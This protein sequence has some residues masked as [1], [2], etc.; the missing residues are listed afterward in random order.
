MSKDATIDR[1]FSVL[2]VGSGSREHALTWGLATSPSVSELWA[3][4]G[5]PGIATLARTLDLP[6]TDIVAIADLAVALQ[7]GLVVVG[8]EAPL[9]FGLANLLRE[10]GIPVFGPTREAAELEWSK[11]FAKA[12]MRRHGIPTADFGLFADYDAAMAFARG[13]PLPLVVKAD[14]LAGGKGVVVCA[15]LAE[16]EGAIRSILLDDAFGAAG[17][18]VVIEEFLPGEELSVIALVDGERIALLPAARDYKRLGDGDSGPNTGG[19]GSYAPVP[20]LDPAL[21]DLVR[22][23]VLEPA[24]AGLR[25]EGR[26]Y[27]GALYAGLML[28]TSGPRVLEFNC[29]FGD[30]E[31][32]AILP[33][34]DVDLARLLYDTAE[35][36]LDPADIAIRPGAAVCV[37]LAAAGYPDTPRAGDVIQGIDAAVDSGA[38]VFHAG[39]ARR[40]G[41]LVTKGGRV[42]SVVGAGPDLEAAARRAY[43]AAGRIAFAGRQMRRDI[44]RLPVRP[45]A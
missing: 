42:L 17:S 20:D 28:T 44:A 9:A 31:T 32:Q 10:R 5:N 2:V 13:T 25:A 1:P 14:G 16:A 22:A 27:R 35:G 39:T 37:V 33:L 18:R 30:P 11:S 26:S 41:D 6:V 24:A 40:D 4:P 3:A 34:L 7:I 15:T 23:T 8:P 12:F 38:L 29:R 45:L 43:D 19:M 21:L 36:K